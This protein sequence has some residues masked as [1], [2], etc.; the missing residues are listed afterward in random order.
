[1]PKAAPPRIPAINTTEVGV[2]TLSE[3]PN[4]RTSMR[5]RDILAL[6]V[7]WVASLSPTATFAQ[8]WTDFQVGGLTRKALV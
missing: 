8:T 5:T 2:A 3:T 4:T 1:M 6:S 7:W